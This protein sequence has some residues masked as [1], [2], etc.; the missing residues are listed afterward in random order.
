MS[1]SESQSAEEC[2]ISAIF[3]EMSTCGVGDR[4]GS[5]FGG[6]QRKRVAGSEENHGRCGFQVSFWNHPGWYPT[7][8]VYF[9]LRR[10]NLN[11]TRADGCG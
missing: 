10:I 7:Q 9:I 6:V 1:H 11:H 8:I 5:L 4:I 2:A 3:P